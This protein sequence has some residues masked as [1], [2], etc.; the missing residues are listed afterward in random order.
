MGKKKKK[1]KSKVEEP[2]PANATQPKIFFKTSKVVKRYNDPNVPVNI[3]VKIKQA[4]AYEWYFKHIG[5]TFRVHLEGYAHYWIVSEAKVKRKG[6]M[7]IETQMKP[8]LMNDCIVLK[9]K[10]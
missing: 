9:K 2:A 3:K 10:K 8:I 4:G 5:E 6:K 1:V 7:I